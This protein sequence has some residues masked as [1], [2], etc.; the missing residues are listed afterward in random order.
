MENAKKNVH[1]TL[2]I[3]A[4]LKS[5]LYTNSKKGEISG[6][7]ADLLRKARQSQKNDLAKAYR[8]AASDAGQLEGMNDMN[9]LEGE[10]FQGV[11]WDE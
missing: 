6:F 4:D 7:V 9:G 5:W 11:E 3:P 1:I 2:S 10:D 8:D